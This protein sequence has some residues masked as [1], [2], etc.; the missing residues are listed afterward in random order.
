M[1]HNTHTQVNKLQY[2]QFTLHRE[3]YAII[4]FLKQSFFL[5]F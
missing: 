4:I 2:N 3:Y 1:L 5:I